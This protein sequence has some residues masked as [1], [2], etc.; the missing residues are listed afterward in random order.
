MVGRD[1]EALPVPELFAQCRPLPC[2]H[3]LF[4]QAFSGVRLFGAVLALASCAWAGEATP[5]PWVR[6]SPDPATRNY[7]VDE[8]GRVRLFHGVSAVLKEFPWYVA[9]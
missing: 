5:L 8:L 9:A 3:P 4:L 7:M 6:V 2:T 1:V